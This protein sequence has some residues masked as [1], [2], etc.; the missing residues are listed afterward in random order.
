MEEPR[1]ED[2]GSTQLWH[3][4]LN[5]MSERGLQVLMNHKFLTNMK[6]LNL[7]FCKHCIFGKY[8]RQKFKAGS[9]VS[10]VFLD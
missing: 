5:H 4:C 7:M 2:S 3:Q 8:C 6:N 1:E 9:H 10:K